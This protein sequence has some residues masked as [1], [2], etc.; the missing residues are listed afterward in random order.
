[1]VYSLAIF[2]NSSTGKSSDL[3][4]GLSSNEFHEIFKLFKLFLIFFLF[5]LNAK[6]IILNK[7]SLIEIS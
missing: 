1:M 2:I 5:E 6:S 4:A 7:L 3:E